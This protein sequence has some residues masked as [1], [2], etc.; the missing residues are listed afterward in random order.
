MY[1]D[2]GC[3]NMYYHVYVCGGGVCVGVCACVFFLCVLYVTF[4]LTQKSKNSHFRI[5]NIVMKGARQDKPQ[6]N[7][8]YE[9]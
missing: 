2:F 5:R 4:I 7:K 3:N 8:M 1:N 9:K 6:S